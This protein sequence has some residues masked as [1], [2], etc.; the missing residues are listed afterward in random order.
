MKAGGWRN[1]I[2]EKTIRPNSVRTGVLTWFEISNG[3]VTNGT[4]VVCRVVDLSS[5][6]RIIRNS[7]TRGRTTTETRALY[8]YC[9]YRVGYCLG[10]VAR[11]YR[12]WLAPRANAGR[13]KE[14]FVISGLM[15]TP[16]YGARC[17]V[18]SRRTETAIALSNCFLIKRKYVVCA[19]G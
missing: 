17:V 11:G 19:H 12:S 10:L 6:G 16:V 2:F 1:E 3:I 5:A 15:K 18:R 7:R 4:P 13:E 8:N 9:Y 14:G